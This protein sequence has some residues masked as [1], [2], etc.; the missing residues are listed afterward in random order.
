MIV[1][2]VLNVP[3]I[4]SFNK[5]GL[6]AFYGAITATILGFLTSSIIAM[7]VLKKKYKFNF[8]NTAKEILNILI[9]VIIMLL[10]LIGLKFVVPLSTPSRLISIGVVLLYSIIGAIVYLFVLY[11]TKSIN[12]IFGEEKVKSLLNKKNKHKNITK[13]KDTKKRG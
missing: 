4:H 12:N 8:E 2:V 6:P 3:L 10:A 5:M 11:K 9:A 7:I 13:K 1:K